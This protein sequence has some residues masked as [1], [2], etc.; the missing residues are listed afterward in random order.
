MQA[1]LFRIYLKDKG[2]ENFAKGS[3]LYQKTLDRLSKKAIERRQAHLGDDFITIEDAPIYEAYKNELKKYCDI[4]LELNWFNYLVAEVGEGNLDAISN[5]DFVQNVQSIKEKTITLQS[6]NTQ[7]Y[8][9]I[10]FEN[11]E[12]GI[13]QNQLDML[14]IPELHKMGFNGENSR[15]G[16]LDSGFDPMLALVK[17]PEN[18]ITN[19]DFVGLDDSVQY[20]SN[21]P[22]IGFHHGTAV[23]SIVLSFHP[24]SLKGASMASEY[25]LARTEDV[26]S[27]TLIE[28]DN[29]AKAI[30]WLEAEGCDLINSSLGY[31]NFED[32]YESYLFDDL[33]GR[34][35]IISRA[36]N[37]G[38]HR[39]MVHITSAGNFGNN[40]STLVAPG[41][42][43][44][45]ISVAAADFKGELWGLSSRGPRKGGGIFPNIMAKGKDVVA[46]TVNEENESEISRGSGT[47][48][49]APLITGCVSLLKSAFPEL[50]SW[51]LRDILFNSASNYEDPNTEIGY[52]IPDMEK[53]FELAGIA[54]AKPSHYQ[55][56]GFQ[57]V[58][59]YIHSENMIINASI[60]VLNPDTE[61]FDEFGLKS[62]NGKIFYGDIPQNYF[63]NDT[64][65]YF[66]KA[67]NADFNKKAPYNDNQYFTYVINN[68]II[69]LGVD[70]L[71][72]PI[73][74]EPKSVAFDTPPKINFSN[75]RIKISNL[76]TDQYY[77][78]R[79]VNLQGKLLL[80]K[81]LKSNFGVI[82]SDFTKSGNQEPLILSI[83]SKNVNI[84]RKILLFD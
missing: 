75:D 6:K 39:G 21:D 16:F 60:S 55:I 19:Y 61:S 51:E 43:D 80:N 7:D 76:Q 32:G 77:D 4:R 53:A 41:E 73:K 63:Q 28:A 64:A 11:F 33:D 78:L 49:S 71:Q 42:A 27:E 1:E 30:E 3:D 47:S 18:N 68:E 10:L 14:N 81:R 8:L 29:F 72:L 74:I 79:L 23:M 13:S 57:R 15:I 70:A 40:D 25:L 17:Y 62:E 24:D 69:A 83:S 31:K 26:G 59:T 44:S 35:S 65:K 37:K 82:Q 34:S 9:N 56:E 54:I 46:A 67:E 12:Y 2:I 50:K 38:V 36:V 58:A 66:I 52:G 22:E 5:L 84:T 48:F 45:V 20:Q